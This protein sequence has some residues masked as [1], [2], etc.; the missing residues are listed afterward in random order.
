MD[1]EPKYD[2]QNGRVINRA[3]GEAIP[4]DEPVFILRGK[5]KHAA[6]TINDYW[7]RIKDESHGDAV[8]ARLRQFIEFEGQNPDRMKEPDTDTSAGDWGEA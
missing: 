8:N 6:D 2:F 3:S 1:Q 4:L 5:D 7:M